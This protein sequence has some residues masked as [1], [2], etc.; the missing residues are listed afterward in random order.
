MYETNDSA[1]QKRVHPKCS[2]SPCYF[3]H[4]ALLLCVFPAV[5]DLLP[6]AFLDV[7]CDRWHPAVS[8]PSGRAPGMSGLKSRISARFNLLKSHSVST[9]LERKPEHVV[10][11]LLQR[12]TCLC[13]VLP[14]RISSA[15]PKNSSPCSIWTRL[16]WPARLFPAG[17]RASDADGPTRPRLDKQ[18]GSRQRV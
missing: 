15:P 6:D 7:T 11:L 12:Q 4:V 18:P 3:R 2:F 5:S 10:S 17:S 1:F 14:L 9:H 13:C 8:A 16:G